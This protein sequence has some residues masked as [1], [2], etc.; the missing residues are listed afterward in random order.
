MKINRIQLENGER[1]I[2]EQEVT[3]TDIKAILIGAPT[4]E[5]EPERGITITHETERKQ[6]AHVDCPGH[7]DYTK[8]ILV[9]AA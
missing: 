2:K 6:Y 3:S 5:S 9:G 7:A 8:S 1:T 4:P